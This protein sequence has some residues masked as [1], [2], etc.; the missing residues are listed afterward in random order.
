MHLCQRPP[1]FL[2]DPH[3]GDLDGAPASGHALGGCGGQPGA[4]ECDHV[5][6]H[7]AVSGMS[8]SVAP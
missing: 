7:E 5:F 1:F 8:A 3:A 4:N 2:H 6:D